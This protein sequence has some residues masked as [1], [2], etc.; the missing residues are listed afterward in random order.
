MQYFLLLLIYLYVIIGRYNSLI[1]RFEIIYKRLSNKG[2]C[3]MTNKDLVR[4]YLY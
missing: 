2:V 1:Q 3:I 4:N